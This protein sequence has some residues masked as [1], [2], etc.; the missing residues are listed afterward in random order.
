MNNTS[1]KIAILGGTGQLG[2][3]LTT[4]LNKY[5]EITSF[6]S[7]TFPFDKTSLDKLTEFS[8]I[9]NCVGFPYRAKTIKDKKS[10]ERSKQTNYKFVI[11]IADYCRKNNK[12]LVHISSNAVY[13]SNNIYLHKENEYASSPDIPYDKDKL[14][15][16][17]YIENNIDNYLIIRPYNLHGNPLPKKLFFNTL[18]NVILNSKKGVYIVKE[19]TA[20]FVSAKLIANAIIHLLTIKQHGVFNISTQ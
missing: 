3:Y 18:T 7:K 9:I 6:S 16:D 10:M 17:L 20:Q 11:F 13:S 5:F 19:L 15:A 8:I 1:R 12:K 14:L 2:N 4:Y